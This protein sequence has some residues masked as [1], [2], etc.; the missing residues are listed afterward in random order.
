MADHDLSAIINVIN[1][2][3]TAVDTHQWALLDRVFT[4]D[5]AIDFGGPIAWEGLESLKEGFAVVH[6][7]FECTQH[8][9]TNH[10]VRVDGDTATC[11]SYVMGRFIRTV[12]EGDNLFESTGWYDDTLVRTPQGWRIQHRSSRMTW[13]GG[14]PAVLQ[15]T[16]Q[17][18]VPET[19][20]S[21]STHAS[22]NGI[23]HLQALLGD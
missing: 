6:T 10:Q 4:P 3:A 8:F 13:W 9:T 22:A 1:L 21:L 23:R 20:D 16:P 19:L 11:L 7:P 15:T 5:I 14:N 12:P 17:A 18:G 2:Y